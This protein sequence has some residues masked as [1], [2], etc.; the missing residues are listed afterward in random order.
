MSAR[1]ISGADKT[2]AALELVTQEAFI[3]MR[4]ST[5]ILWEY[6]TLACVTS[7]LHWEC[8]PYYSRVGEQG[9][10]RKSLKATG[11]AC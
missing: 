4:H 6:Q 5:I 10:A 2:E 11:L 7:Q 9:G 3:R 8:G 1:D